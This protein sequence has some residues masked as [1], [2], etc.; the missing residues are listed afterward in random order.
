MGGEDQ[1]RGGVSVRAQKAAVS[2][3]FGLFAILEFVFPLHKL[4]VMGTSILGN[5]V[6]GGFAAA[7]R[8]FCGQAVLHHSLFCH[9]FS[10]YSSVFSLILES[11]IYL[12]TTVMSRSV[13]VA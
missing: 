10:F 4:S 2:A 8:F 3:T 6:S 13:V 7:P 5:S 1:H 9:S 12:H 11:S